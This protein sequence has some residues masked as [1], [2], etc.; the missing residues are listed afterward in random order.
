VRHEFPRTDAAFIVSFLSSYTSLRNPSNCLAA[1]ILGE[2]PAEIFFAAP[3]KRKAPA[4]S[5]CP[6][7]NS[8]IHP[9][10]IQIASNDEI[11]R[12]TQNNPLI[13]LERL[14]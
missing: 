12:L 10:V 4:E 7:K 1:P 5:T 3:F 14:Q 8:P 11:Q 13:I 9:R 6:L 2:E